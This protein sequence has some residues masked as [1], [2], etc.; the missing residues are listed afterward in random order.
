MEL[1]YKGMFRVAARSPRRVVS[2]FVIAP[3]WQT[4]ADRITDRSAE[5][6]LAAR[7]AKWQEQVQYAWAYDY[8]LVNDDRTRFEAE[9]AAI[10]RAE[11]A[12]SAGAR[13]L[14]EQRHQTDSTLEG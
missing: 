6:N 3:D 13:W 11:L 1:D 5:R 7:A 12:R 9:A 14:L 4:A 8:V 2:I 10:A